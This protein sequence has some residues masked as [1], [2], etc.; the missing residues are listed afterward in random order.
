MSRERFSRCSLEYDNERP[1]E[2]LF[3]ANK[4]ERYPIIER[5]I[6]RIIGTIPRV[7]RVNNLGGNS[8][9]YKDEKKKNSER[10][11]S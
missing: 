2:A 11:S 10:K 5:I 9:G 3:V 7:A 4:R 6:G 8:R 1:N